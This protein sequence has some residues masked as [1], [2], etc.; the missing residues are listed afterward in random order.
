MGWSCLLSVCVLQFPT[1]KVKRAAVMGPA[2]S[3][4]SGHI[5]QQPGLPGSG[6]TLPP[7]CPAWVTWSWVHRPGP[8]TQQALWGVLGGPRAHP[9]E[10]S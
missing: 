7:S 10:V 5:P 9:R 8:P 2:P 4:E 1:A 6:D 3:S